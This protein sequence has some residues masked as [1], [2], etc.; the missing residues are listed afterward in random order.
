MAPG[1]ITAQLIWRTPAPEAAE[2]L[3]RSGIASGIL[4]S[5][6]RSG[7]GSVSP[8]P[9]LSPSPCSSQEPFVRGLLC[10]AAG[11]TEND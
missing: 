4:C 7:T 5:P 3:I 1:S 2:L 9:E 6:S 10:A 8:A 11:A